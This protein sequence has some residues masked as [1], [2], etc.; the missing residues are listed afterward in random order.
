MDNQICTTK[1]SESCL[2]DYDKMNSICLLFQQ[3]VLL[4]FRLPTRL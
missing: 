4:T 1:A 2:T 3:P